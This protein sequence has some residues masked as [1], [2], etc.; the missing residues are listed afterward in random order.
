MPIA[1]I[2]EAGGQ[3]AMVQHKGARQIIQIFGGDA[4]LH[5]GREH[6]QAFG[7]QTSSLAHA[8][9]AFRPV[10]LDGSA[11]HRGF[12]HIVHEGDLGLSESLQ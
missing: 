3:G 9:K 1:A 4:G 6:V 5:V 8:F 11:A 2:E 12:D 7:R 10:H